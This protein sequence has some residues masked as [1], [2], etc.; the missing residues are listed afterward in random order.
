MRRVIIQYH[1]IVSTLFSLKQKKR[2]RKHSYGTVR[3]ALIIILY[4]ASYFVSLRHTGTR[5]TREYKGDVLQQ[6]CTQSNT[7]SRGRRVCL[8]L[9]P[10]VQ[11]VES[12][13]RRRR[14]RRRSAGKKKL[15]VGAN[16]YSTIPV[17]ANTVPIRAHIYK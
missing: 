8:S 5:S 6:E 11:V 17:Q 14:R 9:P 1:I 16:I 4:F 3:R 10:S 2:R 15:F 7:A 13:R 12:R